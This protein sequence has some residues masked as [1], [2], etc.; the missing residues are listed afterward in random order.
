MKLTKNVPE[1]LSNI[2]RTQQPNA[3]SRLGLYRPPILSNIES[4]G[5]TKV[6]SKLSRTTAQRRTANA[7]RR[8][9]GLALRR[10]TFGIARYVDQWPLQEH[11]LRSIDETCTECAASSVITTAV[12]QLPL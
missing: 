4:E 11:A 5:Q 12:E 10:N 9:N 3:K 7:S 8:Q 1:N 6:R 2:E